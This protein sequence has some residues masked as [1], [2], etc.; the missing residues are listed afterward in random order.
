MTAREIAEAV[1]SG[2][3]TAEQVALDALAQN[4]LQGAADPGDEGTAV[5]HRRLHEFGVERSVG[6]AIGRRHAGDAR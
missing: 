2:R 5:L 6:L 3:S 1:R 4:G